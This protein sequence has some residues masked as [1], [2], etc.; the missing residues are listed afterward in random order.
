MKVFDVRIGIWKKEGN[1]GSRMALA[2]N[3]YFM[4]R[5]ECEQGWPGGRPKGS[6]SST[7]DDATE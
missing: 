5:R 4:E 2:L 3:T 7:P 1:V 6:A